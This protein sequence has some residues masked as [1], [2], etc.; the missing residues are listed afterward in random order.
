MQYAEILLPQKVGFDK[1]TL[2][3]SIPANLKIQEGQAV[4][5]NL[6][7]KISYGIILELH[8]ETPAF[9]TR[10]ITEI[11]YEKP[12]LN[13]NQLFLLKWISSHHFTPLYKCL[14]LFL[15]AKMLQGKTVKR[16]TKKDEQIFKPTKE[17]TLTKDQ[18]EAIERI[19]K[20]S[21]N[22]F[23]IQGIT[24]SGKTEIYVKLADEQIK[25]NQQV[26]ILV[27]EISLTPQTISYFEKSL[28][29]KAAVLHSKLSEGERL[30]NWRNIWEE[31]IKLVIGS[32][33]AIFS[34][35]QNL[36]LIIID[37]EHET[38][39]KQDQNPRYKTHKI[40][41][42]LAELSPAVKIVYG[43]ATPSVSTQYE[44]KNNTIKL[45]SRIGNSTLPE[46]Q[47]TDLREEFHKRNFSIF[48]ELLQE[49]LQNVIKK[50]EQAILF[51]N[52]RGTASSVVCRDCGQ[53][54]SC[55]N[56]ELPLT[57]H[58]KTL[59]IPKLICHHCGTITEPPNSCVNCKGTNV[60]YLGIGTQRIET[61]LQKMFP[62]IKILRAD[63]DTT[64]KKDSFE[65]IYQD[66]R[67]HKADIL[68]GTQMI[69][70]GLH[71][72]KVSLVGVIL[73]DIGL[74][75]ADFHTMERNFQLMTQVAGR[76]GRGNIPGKVIIQTYNPENPALK[77][78]QVQNYDQF[79][80]YEIRERQLLTYPPFSHLAKLTIEEKTFTKAQSQAEKLENACWK[81]ARES[82][83]A[84]EFE[85]NTYPAYF[86]KLRGKFRYVVLIKSKDETKLHNLLENLPKEYIMSPTIKIDI[87][88][89]S[90]T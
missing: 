27:P 40:A 45:L 34:P 22:K 23:L 11:V 32:R 54:E 79:Y 83:T 42:K 48:S 77:F 44:L 74:N 19:L 14:K 85:I 1:E 55:K 68:I 17:K 71:L 21:E 15:P 3:Y 67:D 43:S 12:V 25:K 49:E 75:I 10:E 59:N 28:N 37:E 2:T 16:R 89:I 66:F 24:G 62:K 5:I 41:D 46:V 51:I 35:F 65:K 57:Y 70:K 76:A 69:A 80:E 86:L 20:S 53:T 88:P 73:A 61:E 82:E 56:C 8:N 81:I 18:A 90:T 26:L 50:N 87:D 13:H 52:R 9:K 84:E 78:A 72:P 33:S 7:N 58:S 47:I 6:R 31:K 4:K 38:S 64:N 29:L 30:E 39:Y 60:R 36:G 63:K